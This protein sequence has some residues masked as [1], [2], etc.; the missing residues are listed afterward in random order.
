MRRTLALLVMPK[1]RRRPLL[2]SLHSLNIDVVEAEDCKDVRKLLK[3]QMP[4]DVVITQV[5][6]P[7]GNWCD[8]FKCLVDHGVGASVVV[9]S[10][11]ADEILWSEVLWR[12]AY[13]LLIEPY[14]SS[15]V[16]QIVE[17]ALRASHASRAAASLPPQS[18]YPT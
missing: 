17:G 9:S 2:R 5:S 12:G 3:E 18:G 1:E 8:V 6:L 14:E 7:D 16:R 4:V 10:P 13:D 11:R 15:E